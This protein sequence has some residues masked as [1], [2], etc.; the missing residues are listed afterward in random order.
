MSATALVQHPAPAERVAKGRS[1]RSATPR[2]DHD[3]WDPPAARRS[4][5]A[6]LQGQAT[7]RVPE[8]VPIRYARLTAS[9]FAF[10]RGA[11]AI[12]AQDLSTTPSSGLR[13]QI[14]GDAHL[15][16]FGGFAAPDRTIVFDVNDF[17]ETLPGP[18]EWDVKRLA[19]SFEIAGRSRGFDAKT[20][21][22]TVRSVVRSYRDAMH[23]CASSRTLDVW[24]TRLDEHHVTRQF[25]NELSAAEFARYEKSLRKAHS[26]DSLQAFAKLTERVDGK[27][28][29]VSNPPLVVRLQ[30]LMPDADAKQ[31]REAIRDA[32]RRYR[33]TLQPARRHLLEEF[34][35]VDIARKVVGVGSVGTRCW[36]ALLLGRDDSDPLFLQ[37]KEADPS[38]LE[39]YVGKSTYAHHGQRVVEGQRFMQSASDIL[40]GW[41]RFK[42]PDGSEHDVYLRQLWDGKYSPQIELMDPKV[43]GVYAA[44]CGSTMARAHARSGDSIAIASYLGSSDVFDRA[45]GTFADAYADQNQRDFEVVAA[46]VKSGEL[47]AD[48]DRAT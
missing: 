18:W 41:E 20:C 30:E 17:D 10:Y 11:A 13:A 2:Q 12:M 16:N 37:I 40:L 34:E 29:I 36:I 48:E 24:Y 3:A 19:A 26:K 15:V 25:R 45:I 31:L 43:L 32:F 35:I 5:V 42:H 1:A 47:D 8:L 22:K 14:C 46:A 44:M 9:P 7:G 27:I 33:R 21:T 39:P 38:V 28:Q 6:V 4:L 23:A